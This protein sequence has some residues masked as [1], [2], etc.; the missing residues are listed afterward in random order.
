MVGGC[1]TEVD[2]VAP[3]AR[4][5]LVVYGILRTDSDSQYIRI[6]KLFVTRGNAANY[7]S[8]NDLSV[9]ARVRLRDESGREW[10]GIPETVGKIPSQPFYPIHTVY[11]LHMRPIPRQR[12][13]L[14]IEVPENPSL[15]VEATTIVPSPP[16]LARPESIVYLG[17]TPSYPSIDLTK[18][19]IFTFFPQ[20][21]S[22]LPVLAAAYELSFFFH[23]RK[24]VAPGD[25]QQRRF[26]LGPI[27][28]PHQPTTRAQ[29]YTF[30]EKALLRQAYASIQPETGMSL[31]DASP[32]SQAWGLDLTA[33]DTALYQYLRA[34]DPATTD[35]TTV[36]PEYTNIRNG[37]GVFGSA[38]PARRYFRIDPC[39]EYLL[40]LNNAPRPY[41]T[42][43]LE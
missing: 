28:V 36:K 21:E 9:K 39:S 37:L 4:E 7:A 13:F 29:A 18:K 17:P 15:N 38:A 5:R 1:S 26:G 42:C 40:R 14:H 31:Y 20:Y 6:G 35:F 3:E 43:N 12:Y 33:I 10:L 30:A 34:N 23:Y 22:H 8:Q 27:R 25:T 32:L 11:R 2:L 24:V 16:Y 41:T 19:I